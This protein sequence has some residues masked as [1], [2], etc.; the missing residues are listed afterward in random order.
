MKTFI[1]VALRASLQTA[2][3]FEILH[4]DPYVAKIIFEEVQNL[5]EK[6]L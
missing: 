2:I 1:S 5:K 4:V 3:T 6:L